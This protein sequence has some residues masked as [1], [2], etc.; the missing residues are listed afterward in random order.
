MNKELLNKIYKAAVYVRLSREDGSVAELKKDESNSI[1]N[2]KSLI[3]QFI[4]KQENIELVEV[5]EDDGYSGVFFDNRPD[6][7]RMLE[8]IEAGKIDTVIVKDLSRLGR[9]Y[10]EAGR[11]VQDFL[12]VYELRLISINDRIDTIDGDEKVREIII[13][14]LNI[15]NE[16]YARD[17]SGKTRSALDSKCREGQFIGSYAPFGYK[18]SEENKNKLV[19][20]EIVAPIVQRIFRMYISGVSAKKIAMILEQE[21]IPT[22]MDFKREQGIRCGNGFKTYK[23]SVWEAT[24]VFRILKNEQYIGNLVQGKVSKKNF[25]QKK[26]YTKSEEKWIR[27]EN[28]HPAIINKLDFEV[29]QQLL[30]ED[31]RRAHKDQD[32]S[33]FAGKV[34]CGDFGEVMHKRTVKANGSDYMYFRCST[35][36]KDK[37]ACTQHNLSEQ[38]LVKIVKE[39]IAVQSKVLRDIQSVMEYCKAEWDNEQIYEQLEVKRISLED[40]LKK[41]VDRVRTLYEDVKDG[42]ITKE[43]YLEYKLGY[44]QKAVELRNR[45]AEIDDKIQNRKTVITD[46]AWMQRFLQYADMDGLDRTMVAQLIKSIYI[47]E[48]KRVKIVFNYHDQFAEVLELLNEKN[49]I[50]GQE[51]V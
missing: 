23:K 35:H 20:D 42:L 46:D 33:L 34:Y 28:A 7:L 25:K 32:L 51:A 27:Y 47:Y 3:L 38:L 4:E 9:N 19:I 29:V 15:V 8:F 16:Q 1:A 39:S 45:I 26:R 12:D 22:P 17:I 37:E 40:S 5:F 18:K 41:Q 13:P 31:V 6:F 49:I 48:D 21:H 44:Q 50:I 10:V 2:Q 30:I 36:K 43:E 24:T 11:T 14:F